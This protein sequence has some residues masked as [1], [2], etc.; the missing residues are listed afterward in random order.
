MTELK[1]FLGFCFVLFTHWPMKY[2][3]PCEHTFGEH[4]EMYQE[5]CDEGF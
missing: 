1:K 2:L 3:A 5:M 4:W